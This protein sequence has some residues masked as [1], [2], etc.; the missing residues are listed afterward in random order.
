[1]GSRFYK[2]IFFLFNKHFCLY[3]VFRDAI[4]FKPAPAL[5][6][7]FRVYNYFVTFLIVNFIYF[8]QFLNIW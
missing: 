4:Y 5:R 6:P 1:L 7:T 2:I 3:K 8:D